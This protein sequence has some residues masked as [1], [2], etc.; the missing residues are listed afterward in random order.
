MGNGDWLP[1]T[2][3]VDGHLISTSKRLF[4]NLF[5]I[6][7][8]APPRPP[9][10]YSI[11]YYIIYRS[12]YHS[13]LHSKTIIHTDYIFFALSQVVPDNFEMT[14]P[15]ESQLTPQEQ[16]MLSSCSK[17]YCEYVL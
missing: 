8:S 3:M 9:V 16:V 2:L 7:A 13:I 10:F 11:L 15:T 14:A 12:I 5:K 1:G 6:E 17:L 4:G